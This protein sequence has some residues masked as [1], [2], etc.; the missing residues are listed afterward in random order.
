M[1]ALS[2]IVKEF[3]IAVV[4]IVGETINAVSDV[5]EKNCVDIIVTGTVVEPF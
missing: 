2:S 3:F 1:I 4:F 5:E